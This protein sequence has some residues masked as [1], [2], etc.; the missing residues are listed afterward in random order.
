MRESLKNYNQPLPAMPGPKMNINAVDPSF[1]TGD[2]FPHE[3]ELSNFNSITTSPLEDFDDGDVSASAGSPFDTSSLQQYYS[4]SV[5]VR[6]HFDSR[7]QQHPS[8]INSQASSFSSFPPQGIEDTKQLELINE[9]R[10]K[11]RESHNQVERRRRDHINEKI[12][13]LSMLLPE[14][15]TDAQNKP[16]KGIILKRSVDY[17]RHIHVFAEKQMERNRELEVVLSKICAMHG[18]DVQSLGLTVP[19]GTPIQVPP[20]T[21][22]SLNHSLSN[23]MTDMTDRF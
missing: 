12:Q 18:I 14:F 8:S 11:R 20:M 13:E 5:P 19:L 23:Q 2:S 9:R 15:P 17:L 1:L 22:T 21:M 7:I 10:K 6:G 4:M 3:F 16:N